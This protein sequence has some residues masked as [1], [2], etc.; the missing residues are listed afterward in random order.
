[1]HFVN[2]DVN[3]SNLDF[4]FPLF[5]YDCHSNKNGKFSEIMSLKVNSVLTNLAK[6][7]ANLYKY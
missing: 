7:M 5:N 4:S 2:K 3:P 1:M 6:T